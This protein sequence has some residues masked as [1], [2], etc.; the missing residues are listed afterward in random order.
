MRFATCHPLVATQK[1]GAAI[2]SNGTLLFCYWLIVIWGSVY[3]FNNQLFICF[4]KKI[5]MSGHS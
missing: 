3:V 5:I 4:C 1:V 2:L